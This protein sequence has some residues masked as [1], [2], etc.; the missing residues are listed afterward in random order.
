MKTDMTRKIRKMSWLKERLSR[1]VRY[2]LFYSGVWTLGI[3][4]TL[5]WHSRAMIEQSIASL[6]M[7]AKES[8]E[9]DLIIRQ[10]SLL[11]GGVYVPVTPETPPNPYLAQLP[12]RDIETTSGQKLTLINPG[13]M[14]RQLHE[15][16]KK[17]FG[18]KSHMASLNPINPKNSPDEWERGALLAFQNGAA[19]V[20]EVA[21][22]GGVPCFRFMRPLATEKRCLF[23]HEKDG[24]RP[25]EMRCGISVAIPISY[26][27]EEM[28]N[29]IVSVYMGYGAIWVMGLFGIALGTRKLSAYIGH[30]RKTEE[31]L[32]DGEE[33]YRTMM[34]SIGDLVYI[35]SDDFR[36]K[37]VNPAM[38]AKMGR[39][40]INARCHEAI[41][42]LKAPCSWCAFDRLKQGEQ[43]VYV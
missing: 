5:L 43:V 36:I 26:Y 18:S 42:H 2:G 40:D 22:M 28:G 20:G 38:A 30:I 3:F 8:F 14:T 34:E 12:N 32:R 37:Y 11:H 27:W 29:H 4:V 19:E 21:A 25:G 16:G 9:K 17:R 1:A 6:N 39:C 41:Y 31:T 33:K 24:H 35:C 15:L 23:C 10:W 13:Y 7:R